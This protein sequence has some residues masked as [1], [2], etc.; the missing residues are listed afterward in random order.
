MGFE[1]QVKEEF[2]RLHRKVDNGL[3]QTRECYNDF[4]RKIDSSVIKVVALPITGLILV[5]SMI[6][7]FYLGTL[8]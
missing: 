8:F 5:G 4:E 2:A 3:H 7:A 6:A 1:D